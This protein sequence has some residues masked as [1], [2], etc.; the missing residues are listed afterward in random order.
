MMRLKTESDGIM[1]D[2]VKRLEEA[3][4]F[5]R[6]WTPEA[7]SVAMVLGSGYAWVGQEVENARV[8]SYGEIPHFPVTTNPAH[9]GRLLVGTLWGHSVAILQGRLHCYEGYRADEVVFGVRALALWGASTFFLTNAAGAINPHYRIGDFM[10]LSDHLNMMGLNPLVGR[11]LDSL[12]TRFPDL[13][14]LYDKGLRKA[15]L[16][17]AAAGGVRCHEGV[18]G[19]MLGPSYETPAEIRMLKT[20]GADAVGMSTVPEAIALR[21]MGKRVFGLSCLCNLAAGISK[22]DLRDEDIVQVFD[23]PDVQAGLRVVL[24]GLLNARS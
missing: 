16:D 13:S 8:L 20:V 18:Y 17:A 7:P 19:A 15:A 3:R 9:P 14:T 4:D 21:H 22:E 5:L 10:A 23:R 2:M 24:K 6:G 11:N 12:G 1:Q